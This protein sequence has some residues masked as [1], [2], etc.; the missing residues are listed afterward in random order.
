MRVATRCNFPPN[1]AARKSGSGT[2]KIKKR[3]EGH[4]HRRARQPPKIER[5]ADQ[6]WQQRIDVALV[7]QEQVEPANERKDRE[8]RHPPPCAPVG[9]WIDHLLTLPE[10]EAGEDRH[11]EAVTVV[12]R[13]RTRPARRGPAFPNRSRE[14][15]AKRTPHAAITGGVGCHRFHWA[16]GGTVPMLIDSF[17]VG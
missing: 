14:I 5:H 1:A 4:A 12:G 15:P 10:Q 7:V 8:E 9:P 11:E 17:L 13:R 16:S 3:I 6:E 2:M